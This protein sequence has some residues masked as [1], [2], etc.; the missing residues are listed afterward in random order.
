[1][2]LFLSELPPLDESSSAVPGG[3]YFPRVIYLKMVLKVWDLS[4]QPKTLVRGFQNRYDRFCS[5]AQNPDRQTSINIISGKCK[6]F[7][8]LFIPTLP[9]E[10]GDC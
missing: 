4:G 6:A 8:E 9:A 5:V 10:Q 1:M 3:S 7:L 2:R